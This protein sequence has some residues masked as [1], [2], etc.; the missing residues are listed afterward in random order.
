MTARAGFYGPSCFFFACAWWLLIWLL[1]TQLQCG[2]FCVFMFMLM[3]MCP[4]MT[5]EWE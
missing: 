2:L 1:G 5:G 3:F 4:Y